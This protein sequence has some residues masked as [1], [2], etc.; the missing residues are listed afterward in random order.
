VD[1]MK[2]KKIINVINEV[3]Y[4]DEGLIKEAETL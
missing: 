3:F 2:K 4:P 1:V